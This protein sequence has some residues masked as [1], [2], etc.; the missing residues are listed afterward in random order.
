MKLSSAI[1]RF[2]EDCELT[3]G[4]SR[5]TIEN[6]ERYLNNFL[7]FAT[8][9]QKNV[10]ISDVNDK[11]IRQWRM[12]LN[13]PNQQGQELSKKT[14]SYYLIAL[15]SLLDWAAKNDLKTLS[16]EKIELPKISEG[17]VVF[18]NREDLERLIQSP[19]S[20]TL[21]GLRDR[22]ILA[23]LFSTGLRVSEITSLSRK[24]VEGKSEIPIAGKGGKRRVV[25]LSK[26]AQEALKRYLAVRRDSDPALFVRTRGPE[27]AKLALTP[28][29]VQ[30]M[31]KKY[32]LKAGLTEKVTPHTLRH[33][34]ATDLLHH[35]ADLRAVQAMLGH[36]SITTTQRYTHVTDKHLK[37]VHQAFHERKQ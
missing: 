5:K 14:Q 20:K 31:I 36:S 26:Q 28:R 1:R 7:N 3:K 4:L 10:T 2:L 25:F 16:S 30:R 27:K 15:R 13:R 17:E 37:E 23:T 19:S 21:S 29:S 32:A 33:S 12:Q 11:L 6:Y 34:F 8:K 18:L 35:G 22:A 9:N 24:N